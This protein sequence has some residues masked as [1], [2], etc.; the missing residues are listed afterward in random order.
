LYEIFIVVF[1]IIFCKDA[2]IGFFDFSKNFK[3]SKL[4]KKVLKLLQTQQL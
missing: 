3:A 2:K 1:G 4:R